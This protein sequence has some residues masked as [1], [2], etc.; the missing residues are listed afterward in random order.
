VKFNKP[1]L[2]F[3][4]QADL[5]I[6]RGLGGDRDLIIDRLSMVSYYRLSGYW[7]T[8]RKP[9]PNSPDQRLDGFQVGTEFDT[10]W[11]R[12]VFDRHLRLL[13][14]DAI[15]R[16]EI[17]VRTSLAFKHAHAHSPF[18]Y[19]DDPKSLVRLNS[20][21]RLKLKN[22]VNGEYNRSKE[23]F[24]THFKTKYGDSHNDLPVWMAVEIM[25]FGS[26]HTMYRGSSQ[27]IRKTI[28]QTFGVHENVFGT[29]MLTIQTVRNIC[30]HHSRLWNREIGTK[31]LIP[32]KLPEWNTPVQITNNRMFGV[33]TICKW[34]LDRIAPQSS[35]HQRFK[36]LLA[37][38]PNIP[39]V[40]MGFPANW[41]E[42]PIWK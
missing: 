26:M 3:E 9:D 11:Y 20:H 12:Y 30:A 14:M 23:S 15:E 31:P 41:E 34:S 18:A 13:M 6:S 7:Y 32:N 39:L 29:W 10:I 24:V 8:F 27:S 19:A 21:D 36:A 5:L 33:L 22:S 37:E 4:Q 38:Y 2:T 1:A 35:W 40:S 42:S 16:I 28:A 17:A 25:T